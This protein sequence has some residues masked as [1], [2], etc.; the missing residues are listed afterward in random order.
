AG[1][2]S[3]SNIFVFQIFASLPADTLAYGFL[4]IF[5]LGAFLSGVVFAALL[6]KALLAAL[7]RAGIIKEPVH[8]EK[9][10]RL[11]PF[12]FI[13]I[14]LLAFGFAFYLKVTLKGPPTVH[15]K[16]SISKEIN[17]P[18]GNNQL[19]LINKTIDNKNIPT[20]YAGYPLSDVINLTDPAP[21]ASYILI[22]ATDGYSFFLSI[23]ELISNPDILLV[24]NGKGSDRSLDIIGP[25]STKAW[26]RNVNEI[27]VISHSPLII[28]SRL[29]DPFEFVPEEWQT[30]MD[31]ISIDIGNGNQKY[32]G[33]P[34]DLVIKSIPISTEDYIV[35]FITDGNPYEIPISEIKKDGSLRLFVIIN[36]SDISYALATMSGEVLAYPV[37]E[38][39]IR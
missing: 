36:E 29:S 8:E 6:G 39:T 24:P 30:V 10:R 7:N 18:T 3:A 14:S 16:G 2:A 35:T 38:I 34:I 15:I 4:L 20:K 26:V 9:H 11:L 13:G 19:L 12:L 32:Q 21:D 25:L 23:E 31:N 37:N 1:L 33:I 22:K 27:V 28:S 17:F 5:G